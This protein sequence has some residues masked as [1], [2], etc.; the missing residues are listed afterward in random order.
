[1]KTVSIVNP[2]S[3]K[4]PLPGSPLRVVLLDLDGKR[5]EAAGVHDVASV[6]WGIRWQ[7][8]LAFTNLAAINL[9]VATE[10]WGTV[11]A[12]AFIRKASEK[13]LFIAQLSAACYVGQGATL[14]FAPGSLL[15]EGMWG[16]RTSK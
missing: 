6:P 7:S 10:T 3:R 2:R 16:C 1:M 13:P 11:A 12:L 4:H 8:G 9:G 15:V 5:I 14:L